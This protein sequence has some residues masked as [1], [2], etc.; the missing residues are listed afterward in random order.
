MELHLHHTSV[1]RLL[2]TVELKQTSTDQ[3]LLPFLTGIDP[4]KQKLFPGAV[5]QNKR[6]KQTISA[7]F[8]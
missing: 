4:Q 1:T 7:I 3:T 2:F 5:K 6:F 8:H